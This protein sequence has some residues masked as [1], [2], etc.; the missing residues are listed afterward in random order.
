[1]KVR[2][3]VKRICE[4]CKTPMTAV[5]ESDA[6]YLKR[7]GAKLDQLYHGVGCDK[8]R[9]T[10]YKGRLGIYEL[11][12]IND[13]LRDLISRSPNLNDL[14]RAARETGMRCLREDG[15]QKVAAGMTTLEELARVTE[16]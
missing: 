8:C 13:Q 9:R 3:S 2:T 1:M 16:A 4:N 6:S 10:G 11:M 12:E 7:T 5:R 15:L 14:R